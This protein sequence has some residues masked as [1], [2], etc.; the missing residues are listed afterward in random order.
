MEIYISISPKIYQTADDML[1]WLVSSN[2]HKRYSVQDI[3]IL[4]EYDVI[5]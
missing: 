3:D 2:L 5:R 4:T 1:F